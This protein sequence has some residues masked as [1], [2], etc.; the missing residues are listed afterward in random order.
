MHVLLL[1]FV[2]SME[3]NPRD[4]AKRKKIEGRLSPDMWCNVLRVAGFGLRVPTEVGG[5]F[6]DVD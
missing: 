1:F 3:M 2:S 6:P 4:L 5:G